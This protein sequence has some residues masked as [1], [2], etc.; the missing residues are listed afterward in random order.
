MG[1]KGRPR[2]SAE[3]RA[4]AIT[5]VRKK[6]RDLERCRIEAGVCKVCGGPLAATSRR[7]CS[8]HLDS[9]REYHKSNKRSQFSTLKMNAHR[10][11]I[12]MYFTED[13]FRE[14]IDSQLQMCY[15]CEA[16]VADLRSRYEG[17]KTCL[18]VDRKNSSCG[19]GLDNVCLA[20]FRCNAMKSN[21]FSC[22]EWMEIVIK[23]VRPRLA[24][25]HCFK[26]EV[27]K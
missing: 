13:I 8:S 22:S 7:L 6:R 16:T 11:G 12:E 26:N 1:K 2:H 17:K 18:T 10:R 4:K 23:Y 3:E 24:E 9:S 5:K 27:L 21:F 20:C 25:F 14:W 15:Y 19:Y